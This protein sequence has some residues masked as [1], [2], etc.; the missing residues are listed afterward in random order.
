MPND[1]LKFGQSSVRIFTSVIAVSAC[2]QLTHLGRRSSVR[3][4][5]QRG[6]MQG[7]TA[8]PLSV[9]A[10]AALRSWKRMVL[11]TVHIINRFLCDLDAQIWW[12]RFAGFDKTP[13]ASMLAETSGAKA[14]GARPSEAGHVA[15][16]APG[17]PTETIHSQILRL[18]ELIPDPA[19]APPTTGIT[20]LNLMPRSST[21][22]FMQGVLQDLR[23]RLEQLERQ[24]LIH[25]Q[26]R[27]T[28]LS[29]PEPPQ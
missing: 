7:S 21:S 11:K 16:P 3:A 6:A 29:Q 20:S 2:A 25:D 5:D 14:V 1:L 28:A 9:A 22:R 4:S 26:R 27:S 8:T 12:E 17:P 19:A 13:G 24:A 10:Y 18:A 23:A 15:L